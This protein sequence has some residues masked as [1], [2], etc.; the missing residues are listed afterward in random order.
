MRKTGL[1]VFALG[2]M[3]FGMVGV[4][5]ANLID[6]TN[7]NG[8]MTF[9]QNVNAT[10]TPLSG[11]WLTNYY[12]L[13]D[14]NTLYQIG[15]GVTA[16]FTAGSQIAFEVSGQRS[17]NFGGGTYGFMFANGPQ[18]NINGYTGYAPNTLAAN[19]PSNSVYWYWDESRGGASETSGLI[20]VDNTVP[21]PATLLLMGTGLTGL[22]AA[23][24]RKKA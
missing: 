4:A 17:L 3:I 24:R 2:V 1:R 23:R 20:T 9:Q 22:V 6:W 19:D 13:N 16:N 8:S 5:S 7:S 12:F 15:N 21:E 14:P 11:S 18:N 10:F